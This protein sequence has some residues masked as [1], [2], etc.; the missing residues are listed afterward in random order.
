MSEYELDLSRLAYGE[1]VG[2]GATATV[3]RG[4]LD[5]AV[6]VAIKH[7]EFNK[8]M[9]NDTTKKAFD[10]EVAIM[11][12]VKHPNLV[13]FMGVS[14]A[15]TPFRIVTEFCGGGCCFEL[16]HTNED[17]ILEWAQQHKMC[18]DVARAIEYLHNFSP[19]IIHRDLKSLNLLL[20]RPVTNGSDQPF[21]KVSDFGLSRMQDSVEGTEAWG[22]MTIAAGTCHWMAP[23]VFI[24]SY[25]DERVDVYSFAMIIYEVICREIPF[26][27]ETPAKVAELLR[28][29]KRPDLEGVPP[30]CPPE[31][32]AMKDLMIRSWAQEPNDRPPFTQIVAELEPFARTLWPRSWLSL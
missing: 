32:N 6:E 3:Y 20:A 31:V 2:V 22:K 24:N 13:A 15:H 9:I 19:K 7:M 27:E 10:R 5:S 29:N 14:S 8:S 16:L 12:K 18:L 11:A 4:V 30:D 17:I 26:E 1:E 28:S 25:Y 23:E 21:V